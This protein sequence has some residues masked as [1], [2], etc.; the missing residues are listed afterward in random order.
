[1]KKIL[2]VSLLALFT[3]VT[4]FTL[5]SKAQEN[6]KFGVLFTGIGCPHCA[7]VAPELEDRIQNGDVIIIEYEL[8]NN[9][10]NGQILNEYA[11]NYNLSLGIP[12]LLFNKDLK[13]VGDSPIID[14]L[15]SMISQAEP[16]MVYLSDGKGTTFDELNLNDLGRYPTI[17]SKDRVAIRKSITTLSES[18]NSAI[19]QFISTKELDS[20][21]EC[22]E[23]KTTEPEKVDTLTGKLVYDN[24][25]K[26]NGWLLQWNGDVDIASGSS[27]DCADESEDTTTESSDLSIGRIITLGLADSVNPCA[28]SI[29]ALVLISI[30]TYNPGSRKDIFLAG[31]A[32]ILSVLVMYFIYGILIVKA[33]EVVNS[34]TVIRQ[35]L[36]GNLG[37][38]FILGIGAII[39]GLLGLKD[40]FSYKPGSVGTEMPMFLRPK[41]SKLISKVTSPW[42]AFSIGLFVTLFL[43]PCTIGPYV[44]LGGLLVDG[45]IGKALL[46]LLLYDL[47]FVLPMI[48]VVLVVYIGSKKAE[49]V[50]DWRDQNVRYMHLV[51]GVLMLVIGV[52]MVLGKF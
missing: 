4:L 46:P 1:M 7:K 26:V 42:A 45:G 33:F 22:L 50:K 28:L 36:Y 15:D 37:L 49:Q 39:L 9:L 21:I 8:Y 35:F 30:V 31:F 12:Q 41:V 24:A 34:I 5:N 16:N 38:N 43:L 40:F 13:G 23:G 18:E 2:S 10:A 20:A 51:A 27:D 19:K 17:Y 25:L 32:F 48:A 29:L 52:L 6:L 47:V 11:D 14:T 44:I 3:L